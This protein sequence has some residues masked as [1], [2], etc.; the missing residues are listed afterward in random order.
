MIIVGDRRLILSDFEKILFEQ[1]NI[2]LNTEALQKVDACYHFLKKF[3]SD[4]VIYGINTGFGPMAQ[5]KIDDNKRIALQY[6][7]IRS[8]CSGMGAAFEEPYIRS[9]MLCQLNTLMQGYSGVNRQIVELIT[10]FINQGIYPLVFEHGGV[11]AS[12]D[13]VQLAHLAL[14]YIG[15]GEVWFKGAKVDCQA[16]L[17]QK[18][19]QP[20][21]IK[22]REGLSLMNGT[23]VMT[24][25]GFVNAALAKNLLN[26]A[27]VAAAF[28]QEIVSAYDDH[29]SQELNNTKKHKG[30]SQIAKALRKVLGDSQQIECRQKHLYQAEVKENF[31]K[32]KVQE[33]YSLRCIPQ[34]L[35]PIYD[36]L[37]QTIDTLEN[38]VNSVNDNP[39]ID[40]ETQNVYHGGNFH[41]DYVSLAMD[42]LRLAMTKL[43]MLAE[44]Q[45]NFLLNHKINDILPPFVNL[46]ELG[47]NFGVQGSQFTATSTTAENQMLSNSMYVHSIPNNNDNQDVVSMG[48]NSASATRRV[49]ENAYQVL[50]IEFVAIVQAISYLKIENKL[51]SYTKDIYQELQTITPPFVEDTT[52]YQRNNAVKDYLQDKRLSILEEI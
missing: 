27:L 21:E 23:S 37:K 35:G 18:N 36:N 43:S 49:I 9:A 3:A 2:K 26:W 20:L 10:E 5:Y 28:M 29:Y 33:Y 17:K 16:I 30:Q 25:V 14:G 6:N 38:E 8:H 52:M 48:T 39:I 50:A 42:Q 32:K 34:I 46:G 1:K 40:L 4:K 22:L 45:L 41:G 19:I 15:E 7:L 47:F 11:G 12:G 13:L 31:I 24:G 44:R 51:S